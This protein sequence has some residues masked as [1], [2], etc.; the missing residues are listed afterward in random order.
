[1]TMLAMDTSNG[2]TV[3]LLDDD[4][5]RVV[6]F[7]RAADTREHVEQLVPAIQAALAESGTTPTDIAT[8]VVGTGPAPFTGLRVGIV[9]AQSLAEAVGARALG[10]SSLDA[11]AL[12]WADSAAA[13][14]RE[15]SPAG[16]MPRR[17]LVVG[18]ARRREVY[19]AIYE[20]DTDGASG[21]RRID[22]PDIARPADLV[23]RIDAAPAGQGIDV[24]GV[25]AVAGSAS[26]L[27]ADAWDALASRP[28]RL[29][30]RLVGPPGMRAVARGA[31]RRARAGEP[32]PLEPAYLRRPDVQAAIGR[33]RATSPGHG[34]HAVRR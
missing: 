24:V 22:G 10:I 1:M 16:A 30:S 29:P 14:A 3:A 15:S 32:M 11:E 19:W 28:L 34:R 8:V 2:S 6:G 27:Y 23:A 9:T 7:A 21:L 13:R 31:L 25:D 26:D 12:A 20:R 18:D 17:L 33:K 4:G 5:A